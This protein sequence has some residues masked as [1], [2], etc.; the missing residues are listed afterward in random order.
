MDNPHGLRTGSAFS[1]HMLG[2]NMSVTG[3]KGLLHRYHSSLSVSL[4]E[5]LCAHI[6]TEVFLCA[7]A[8]RKSQFF[9]HRMNVSGEITAHRIWHNIVTTR[10]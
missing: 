2:S 10:L 9:E 8:V 1:I 4:I 6:L 7:C 5:G 3:H